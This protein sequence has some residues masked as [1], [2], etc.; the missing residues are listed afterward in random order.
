M[1]SAAGPDIYV[2][3]TFQEIDPERLLYDIERSRGFKP[4]G[5]SIDI[6]STMAPQEQPLLDDQSLAVAQSFASLIPTGINSNAQADRVSRVWAIGAQIGNIPSVTTSET[7]RPK[8]FSRNFNVLS[9]K[10]RVPNEGMIH[11]GD[12]QFKDG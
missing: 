2:G 6:D 11:I 9:G 10:L 8:P 1:F 7:G 4:R 3:G 12:Q 5:A